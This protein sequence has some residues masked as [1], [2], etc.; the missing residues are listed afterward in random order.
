MCCRLVGELPNAVALS[1]PIDSACFNDTL[2][3]RL[4]AQRIFAFVVKTRRRILDQGAAPSVLVDGRVDDQMVAADRGGPVREPQGERGLLRIAKPLDSRFLLMVKHNALFAALLGELTPRLR[5]LALVRNPVAVLASWA[6]VDLPVR[7]G[8]VPAAERFA[9]ALRTAL[10]R[11]P[12]VLRRRVMVLDWFFSRY[13]SALRKDRILRYEDVVRDGAAELRQSLG[14]A[15]A[16][17]AA[18]L[19]NRNANA[20]Y[21]DVA[22]AP[23]L[24]ALLAG[25]GAWRGFYGV[26][27]CRAAADALAR[28][29]SRV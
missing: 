10:D 18:R 25:D 3:A 6:T 12:D 19:S 14:V 9:P 29:A 8:R 22:A 15:A 11:E 20:L 23:L 27:D 16:V 13:Q 1:E 26:E 2:D 28:V 5:C 7:R 24:S 17:P 21:K 4:A